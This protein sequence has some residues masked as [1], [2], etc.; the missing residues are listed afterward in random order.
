MQNK[1]SRSAARTFIYIS[2]EQNIPSFILSFLTD[3]FCLLQFLSMMSFQPWFFTRFA[4]FFYYYFFYFLGEGNQGG[5]AVMA[6]SELTVPM[7]AANCDLDIDCI[8]KLTA[9]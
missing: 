9:F 4:V 3:H 5:E 8:L 7:P 2:A 1:C 6:L